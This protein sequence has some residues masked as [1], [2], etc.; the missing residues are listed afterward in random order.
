MGQDRIE[1]KIVLKAPRSRVWRALSDSKEFGRWFG[2][3]LESPF[4]PG[5]R[6]QG[7]ITLKGY[8]HVK[9]D[10]TIERIEPETLLSYRWHPY[11]VQPGVDYSAEPT[12]L[13]EFTLAEV[14]GG[15]ELTVLESGFDR[16][17]AARRAEAFRMND[18]GWASQLRNIERHVS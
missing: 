15:T 14:P 4:A 3:E 16:I 5:A 1:K 12:T 11:A 8:E 13:V 18:T 7:Q 9:M 2:V 6:V 10:I 17:P